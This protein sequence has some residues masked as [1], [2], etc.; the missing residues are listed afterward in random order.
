MKK[1]NK[2]HNHKDRTPE[3][4]Q[5]LARELTN[6]EELKLKFSHLLDVGTNFAMH[7]TREE[8]NYFLNS[9]EFQEHHE[10]VKQ[11]TAQACNLPV[12]LSLRSIKEGKLPLIHSFTAMLKFEYGPFHASLTVDDVALS[13][14]RESI[15]EPRFDFRAEADFRAVVGDQGGWDVRRDDYVKRMSMADRHESKEE[16]FDVIYQSLSEKAQVIDRLMEVIADYNRNK[17]YHVFKCNCQHFVR[18]A[19]AALGIHRPLQFNG[20]LQQRFEQLKRGK[21]RVPQELKS[22][23][24]VD[25]YV[26]AFKHELERQDMEYLQCLYFDFHLPAIEKSNDPDT[27]RC[28]IPTCM[29]E[30]LDIMIKEN[31]ASLRPT[32]PPDSPANRE[33]LQAIN[34]VADTTEVVFEAAPEFSHGGTP[35]ASIET[36]QRPLLEDD[37]CPTEVSSQGIPISYTHMV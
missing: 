24:N 13:W 33:R 4:K 35:L 26:E 14:G 5:E 10:R 23:E 1:L 8:E 12:R 22:H 17:E 21:L 29:S 20:L 34:G 16:K 6:P 25:T 7:I 18:D 2:H 19:M 30:E 11:K 27:W 31:C 36:S 3:E 28:N 32:Q 9:E 37:V 15:V